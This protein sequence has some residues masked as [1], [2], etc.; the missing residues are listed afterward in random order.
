M[1]LLS[2]IRERAAWNVVADVVSAALFSAGLLG[3]GPA[4]VAREQAL[5]DWIKGRRKQILTPVLDAYRLS[6]ERGEPMWSDPKFWLSILPLLLS[7]IPQV[8]AM[9]PEGGAA[10]TGLACLLLVGN[11][12]RQRMTLETAQTKERGAR[13]LL[14]ARTL[15]TSNLERAIWAR[16]AGFIGKVSIAGDGMDLLLS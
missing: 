13:A 1:G 4:G 5:N 14:A 6:L 12:V 2:G 11:Y 3:R 7:L 16:E 9:V 15:E 10:Y 8:Q